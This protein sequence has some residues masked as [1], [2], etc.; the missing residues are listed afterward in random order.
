MCVARNKEVFTTET[1]S[2]LRSENFF[3]KNCLL[4][5][6]RLR[7]AI[8]EF[9]VI[10]SAKPGVK[11]WMTRI[12]SSIQIRQP[13][14][15]VFDFITTPTNWPQWHP[16]SVSVGGDADHSL[17]PGEAVTENISV[18]GRRGRSAGWYGNGAHLIDG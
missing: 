16:A 10:V 7:G 11:A 2:S 18:A 15:R 17:L 9:R 6:L 3:T 8:S 14:E 1:Q 13:I 12:C 5:V 4:R